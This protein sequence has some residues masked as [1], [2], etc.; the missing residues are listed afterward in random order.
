MAVEILGDGSP[1]GTS[2]GKSATEKVGLYGGTPVIQA[3]TIADAVVGPGAVFTVTVSAGSTATN[4]P[5][6]N[7]DHNALVTIVN[8]LLD[9]L[10][11]LGIHAS[12]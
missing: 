9:D 3:A 1:D 8:A 11:D 10:S 2:L 12:S 4:H 5:C 7:A 6:S